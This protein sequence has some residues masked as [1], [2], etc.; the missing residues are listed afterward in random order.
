MV[1]SN[2]SWK[3]LSMKFLF[4]I[5]LTIISLGNIGPLTSTAQ[6]TLEDSEP[7]ATNTPKPA[8]PAPLLQA[9][10]LVQATSKLL[11][12]QI[13]QIE[14]EI[15]LTAGEIE[16]PL[17]ANAHLITTIVAPDKVKTEITFFDPEKTLDRQYQVIANGTQVWIYDVENNQYSVNEYGQFISSQTGLAVG[18][19]ANFYLK[20]LNTINNNRIASRAI[21]KL[22]P[23]R[24]FRYFQSYANLDL[25]NIVIRNEQIGQEVYA[26]YDLDA[27]DKS[28]QLTTY[29][30]PQ[31]SDIKQIY[32]Q[33]KKDDLDITLI[34]QI[35]SQTALELMPVE[36]FNFIPPDD[37]EQ[38][39]SQIAIDIF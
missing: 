9:A 14:S 36:A 8:I 22:P 30:A 10:P 2:F 33:G 31:S 24:L 28:Y 32:L 13:Y 6:G 17:M 35:I 18:T 15:E 39:E 37:A 4:L 12:Q 38:V 3:K 11:S 19:L 23:D 26:V 7:P 27:L 20:T 25:Q 1:D 29:I 21:G 5:C 34:E 16:E